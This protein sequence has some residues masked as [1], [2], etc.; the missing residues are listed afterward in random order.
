MK[1]IC[2]ANTLKSACID[3]AVHYFFL[4]SYFCHIYQGAASPTALKPPYG[5]EQ[6]LLALFYLN[7]VS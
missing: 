6:W 1:Q 2:N 7:I 4:M 5:Q 3:P